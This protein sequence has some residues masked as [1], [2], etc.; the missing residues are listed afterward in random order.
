MLCV[1]L[2]IAAVF[3][4]IKGVEQKVGFVKELEFIKC[5]G[6]RHGERDVC[7]GRQCRCGEMERAASVKSR[8]IDR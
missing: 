5:R 7:G 6:I 1:V 4:G 3:E 2:E 8:Q